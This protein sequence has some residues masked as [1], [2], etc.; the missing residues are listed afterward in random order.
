MFFYRLGHSYAKLLKLKR[1]QNLA[2]KKEIKSKMTS[3]DPSEEPKHMKLDA[4]ATTALNLFEPADKCIY[5]ILNVCS[6]TQGS[7]LLKT[8]IN[9]PLLC[10]ADIELRYSIY[11]PDWMQ[12]RK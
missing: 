2:I 5:G 4:V 11:N 12:L 6:T 10:K 8:W 9:Q 3:D 7:D 1:Y